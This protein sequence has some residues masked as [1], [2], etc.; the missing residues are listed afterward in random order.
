MKLVV[1]SG[2]GAR[3]ELGSINPAARSTVWGYV[4]MS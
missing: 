3:I 1:R 4:A 2:A